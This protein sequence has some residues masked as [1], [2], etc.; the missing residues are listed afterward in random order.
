MILSDFVLLDA[1]SGANS[2]PWYMP[3][4]ATQVTL[5]VHGAES[6]NVMGIVDEVEGEAAS[7]SAINL[8]DFSIV[9]EIT[10]DGIYAIGV[11]GI[12]AIAVTNNGTEGA[13]KVFGVCVG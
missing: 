12:K 6:L 2:N 1:N 4:E 3:P 10:A 13:V 11:S 5:Q 9:S 7:L 8:A